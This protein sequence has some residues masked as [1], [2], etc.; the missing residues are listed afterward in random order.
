MEFQLGQRV[1]GRKFGI[2]S[3]LL[4]AYVFHTGGHGTKNPGLIHRVSRASGNVDVE[5][6]YYF[7]S[8][9][10]HT[11]DEPYPDPDPECVRLMHEHLLYRKAQVD[12]QASPIE[13]LSQ[14]HYPWETLSPDWENDVPLLVEKMDKEIQRL[15]ERLFG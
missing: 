10:V 3:N 4:E 6:L 7:R 11:F 1:K 5:M 14:P 8:E 13:L 2:Y 12:K 9:I 15:K